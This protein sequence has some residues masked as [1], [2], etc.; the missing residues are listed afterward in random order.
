MTK[1]VTKKWYQS[2]TIQFAI[3]TAILTVLM[4]IQQENPDIGFLGVLISLINTLLRL[5]T[6]ETIK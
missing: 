1:K 5:D 2:R 4:A 6:S 3:L